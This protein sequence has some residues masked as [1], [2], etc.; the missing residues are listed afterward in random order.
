MKRTQLFPIKIAI[1]S[2]FLLYSTYTT[3]SILN[4]LQSKIAQYSKACKEFF[5]P[6]VTH[7]SQEEQDKFNQDQNLALQDIVNQMS[8]NN[9]CTILGAH[10][11]DEL[12]IG[13]LFGKI[14]R[15]KTKVGS[16]ILRRLLIPINDLETILSRQKAIRKLTYSPEMLEN[17]TADLTKIALAENDLIGYWNIAHPLDAKVAP[18]Y[19]NVADW[20]ND[21][22]WPLEVAY[23]S[24]VGKT[25]FNLV[26]ILCLPYI[27]REA[28]LALFNSDRESVWPMRATKHLGKSSYIGLRYLLYGDDKDKIAAR[29]QATK[30]KNALG[31]GITSTVEL[32]GRGLISPISRHFIT[33]HLYGE[34]GELLTAQ[35]KK[36]LGDSMLDAICKVVP[37]PADKKQFT[38]Q[39]VQDLKAQL[40][41]YLE[42]STAD[43]TQQTLIRDGIKALESHNFAEHATAFDQTNMG[44]KYR[45]MKYNYGFRHADFSIGET[46]VPVGSSL[47]AI[48]ALALTGGAD[49]MFGLQIRDLS[50]H[51]VTTLRSSNDLNA[52][53]V[54]IALLVRSAHRMYLYTQNCPELQN[55]EGTRLLTAFFSD[56]HP[57]MIRIKDILFSS[58]CDID[59]KLTSRGKTLLAH[60][61]I[62]QYRYKFIPLLQAIGYFDALCSTAQLVKEH[63]NAPHHY[64][65]VEFTT[66]TAPYISSQ[67]S[68]L[69]LISCGD[70]KTNNLN[71]GSQ[72]VPTKLIITGPNG[73]GKSTTMK[74]YAYLVICGQSLGIVPADQS[75]QALFT[76]IKTGLHPHEDISTGQSKFMAEMRRMHELEIEARQLK[77]S[78]IM[79]M[80]VDEPYSGTEERLSAEKV[81]EFGLSMACHDQCSLIMATHLRKPVELETMTAGKYANY[82][83]ELLEDEIGQFTRTYQFIPG[84]AQW[85][86]NDSEKASRFIKHLFY[87]QQE[88]S[89]KFGVVAA[90]T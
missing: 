17:F 5:I 41:G 16:Q 39:E 48:A 89:Y 62:K 15:T 64:S 25:S 85:W 34:N 10:E 79:L 60:R 81:T 32:A 9:E 38:H 53:I 31:Y 72:G 11:W 54:H 88:N 84:A 65:F 35:S 13:L 68:W 45:L 75:R 7:Q 12:E 29:D 37:I 73:G 21:S 27:A 77:Q 56:N 86:F 1:C 69:P 83:M 4:T 70:I 14:N 28:M 80:L 50:R 3:P 74:Q 61:L 51:L 90:Q 82:Q 23:A 42:H 55:N 52:Q 26:R 6:P 67:N 63:Q 47:A 49:W 30:L 22:R 76:H 33:P 58:T 78:E 19:Y 44:D 40:L 24:E 20:L 36:V 2:T 66:D 8:Y 18:L 43:A 57:D 87:E 46:H 59:S 71:L